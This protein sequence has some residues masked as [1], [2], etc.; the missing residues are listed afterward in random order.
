MRAVSVLLGCLILATTAALADEKPQTEA[1]F[2]SLFNGKNLD[3]WEIVGKEAGW[4]VVDGVI[5]SVGGQGGEWLRSDKPYGDYILKVDWRVSPGG[6]SGV[7]IRCAKEGAPWTS[8]YEIQISN[9]RQDLAHCT[10]SLYGYVSVIERPDES[11]E[12][13]HTFEIR[14]QGPHI[15]V[16]SDGVKCI[17]VDQSQVEGITDKPLAGYIGLQDS[18]S[19]A[20][21]YIEYRN[22]RIKPL[23]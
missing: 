20:G 13:W 18:H 5:R 22:V 23:K 10:G 2:T 14:C 11:A 6:N 7:F 16:L 9:P 21:N 3:G 8:G 1:G 12:K 15:T 4:A 17:D 19:A